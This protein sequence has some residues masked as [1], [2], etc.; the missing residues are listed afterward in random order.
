M[1]DGRT[2][3]EQPDGAW[4][5]IHQLLRRVT[6]GLEQQSAAAPDSDAILRARAR[7]Y[8]RET[9]AM[10]Q[11]I[12]EREDLVLFSLGSDTYGIECNEIE[13]VIPLQNLVALPHTNKGIMGI[14]SLRGIL[15]AVIDL[16]RIL[17]IPASDL[18]T[19]HRV[20][21]IRHDTFKVGFLVD[22]VQGMR[23][24]C[25][26]ELQELPSEVHDRSRAYLHGLAKGNVLLLN[27]AKVLEDPLVSGG[28]QSG[29]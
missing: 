9:A 11:G 29:R 19:M 27:A 5:E 7:G 15:F 14:S 26:S 6:A 21:M 10:Q 20:L 22:S 4:Q 23:S 8:A 28:E 3:I 12:L 24:F 17:N 1:H 2:Q 13:E 25:R 16:K 18:T